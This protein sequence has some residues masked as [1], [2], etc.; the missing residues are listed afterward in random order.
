MAPRPHLLSFQAKHVITDFSLSAPLLRI[1]F[2]ESMNIIWNRIYICII[3]VL[4]DNI[5]V[6]FIVVVVFLYYLPLWPDKI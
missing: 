3:S 6:L 4:Y 5:S 1:Y 2:F